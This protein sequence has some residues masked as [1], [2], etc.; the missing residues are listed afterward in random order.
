MVSAI[1]HI[2]VGR[3]SDGVG[4]ML[5]KVVRWCLEGVGLV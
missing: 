5:R 3:W 1:F 4:K 2:G